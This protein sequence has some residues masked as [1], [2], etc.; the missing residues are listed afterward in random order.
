[1]SKEP[2]ELKEILKFE[3]KDIEAISKALDKVIMKI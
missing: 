1:M 3:L 2:I